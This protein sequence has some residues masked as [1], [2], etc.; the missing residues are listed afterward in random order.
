MPRHNPRRPSRLRQ[1]SV[2]T[3][4]GNF[5]HGEGA[6]EKSKESYPQGESTQ[7]V[8]SSAPQKEDSLFFPNHVCKPVCLLFSSPPQ[9]AAQVFYTSIKR[10]AFLNSDL[11]SSFSRLCHSLP[12]G[13]CFR[14]C[15][16]K[17][18]PKFT[19]FCLPGRCLMDL[20][21]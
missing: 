2:Q 3:G 17:P 18:V 13:G 21:A 20:Y 15:G 19:L 8:R 9:G 12:A 11:H 16:K 10:I 6:F 7:R 4:C 5:R 14:L 1:W